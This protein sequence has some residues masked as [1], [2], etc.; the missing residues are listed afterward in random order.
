MSFIGAVAGPVR[1]VLANW[2]KDVAYDC[3][4]IGA[5]NFTVPSA[6]IS[7]GYSGRFH[8][9]DVSLYTSVLGAYLTDSPMDVSEKSDC[10]EQ[11]KGLLTTGTPEETAAS[12]ALIYDLRDVWQAKNPFQVRVISSN[13]QAWPKLMEQT[14]AKIK[15]YKAHFQGRISYEACCGFDFLNRFEPEKHSVLAFPPTY[16]QGYEKLEKLLKA[17]INWDPPAYREMTDQSQE[18]YQSIARF[19]SW[20]V[21]LEKDLPQAYEYIGNPKAVLPRG[22][23]KKTYIV[24]S[25]KDCQ[26]VVMRK[27]VKSSSVGPLFPSDKQISGTEKIDLVP[28]S[29]SQTLRLNELF[30]ASHID[31][32]T[33]GVSNSFGFRLDGRIF[34]K[35]DFA[36]SSHQW[37]LPDSRPMIYIM[38]DLAIP[39]NVRRL[40]KLVLHCLLSWDVKC[41]L[42]L[43]FVEDF[44]YAATTAFSK[45]PVSM[46]YR[47]TFKLHSR[48]EDDQG[49]RLNYYSEFSDLN[50]QQSFEVW[51]KKHNQ[52]P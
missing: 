52:N 26:P 6:M 11:L 3:L 38:S 43:H 29:L 13:R 34:G 1:Q 44:G 15:T 10:P 8:C 28:L 37:K 30:M 7:G 27:P 40:S 50:I 21:V 20:F 42:D 23:N 12:V 32:F 9:C 4:V 24:T 47:G 39:S 18:L 46:K 22:R 25:E 33:G 49:F 16:R 14:V 36:P 35:V 2:S 48:K 45:N 17:A 41:L 31:Y 19:A 5:G 51:V